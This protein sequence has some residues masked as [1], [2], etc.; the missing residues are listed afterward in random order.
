MPKLFLLGAGYTGMELVR[1]LRDPARK[2]PWEIHA[3]TRDAD[4]R[5]LVEDLGATAIDFDLLEDDVDALR[6]HIAEGAWVVYT[7][8]TLWRSYDAAEDPP[9]HVRPVAR[10]FDL[11]VERGAKGFVYT[12]STSV[13]GDHDGERIDEESERRP[14]SDLGKMRRDIEEILLG[15]AGDLDAIYIARLVGIYGPGRTLDRYI[16]GG[17]YKLVDGGEKLT[18]RVHVTDIAR[19][20][21]ALMTRGPEGARDYNVTDG[22]PVT[23]RELVEA[24]VAWTDIERPEEVSME[25]YAATRGENAAARWRNSYH[26]LNDRLREET[27]WEPLWEDALAGYRDLFAARPTPRDA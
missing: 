13:Y 14:T 20:I 26:C 22:N 16:K 6:P 23:V 19:A 12:S 27:G 25:E 15:R 9:R 24:V 8:P 5:A 18:N 3:T 21:E 4:K 2:D 10:V 1:Q 17:R 7:A 11:A